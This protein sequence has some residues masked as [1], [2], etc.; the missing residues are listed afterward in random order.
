MNLI[1]NH[2]NEGGMC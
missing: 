2:V 1:A